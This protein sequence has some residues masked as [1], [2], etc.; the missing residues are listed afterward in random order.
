[1]KKL[2]LFPILFVLLTLNTFAQDLQ[3]VDSTKWLCTYEYNFLL[4]STNQNSLRH[5]QMYL[6]IGSHL[7]KFTCALFFLQD[8]AL[9][10]TELKNL[11]M[12]TTIN[13]V[14][15]ST[16]G[17]KSSTL[18]MY[19]IYKNFPGKGLMTFNAFDDKYYKVE[20]PMKMKW[21]LVTQKDTVIFGYSCQ[22]ARIS[23]A[24]RDWVA[25]YSPQ[26]PVADGPY[27]FNGLPG[28]ILNISDTRNQ[29]CFTLNAI[30]KV[31]YDQLIL[32]STRIS[33]DI[34]AEEYIKAKRNDLMRLYGSLQNGTITSSSEEAK[35][36][37]MHGIISKNNFIENYKSAE[38][39]TK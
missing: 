36:Q 16:N 34:T 6:Q 28:L 20:Q 30:K 17:V 22:M 35:A 5:D 32:K 26:I 13:Q 23:Y 31:T 2:F 14:M 18:S 27:K 4:D 29:H 37:A 25:W 11:D 33:V 12:A 9:Y 39:S 7:S 8:S 1:M 15:K 21:K 19:R 10:F 24:G 38:K 3:P